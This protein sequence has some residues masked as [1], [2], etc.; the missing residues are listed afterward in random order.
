MKLLRTILI[1]LLTGSSV[2][3]SAV[4]EQSKTWDPPFDGRDPSVL[5][6]P[7]SVAIYWRHGWKRNP[8]D[9]NGVRVTG[10]FPDARYFS[11]N[12]YNDDTKMTLGSF[13]D[14]DLVPD[15]GGIN[16]FKGKSDSEGKSSYTIDIL[17]EGAKSD[18]KNV[19][20][21][22]DSVQNVSFLL[23]FYVSEKDQK[24]NRPLPVISTLNSETGEVTAGAPSAQA[25]KV[26]KVEIQKYL[27]PMFKEM[28]GKAEKNPEAVIEMIHKR[29]QGDSLSVKELV[30]KQVVA[31][32]FRYFQP[33]GILESYNFN[34]SGTY[35]NKDNHY[36]VIPVIRKNDDVLVVKFRAPQFPASAKDYPTS[37]VR[38]FSLSQGDDITYNH[39]TIIDR[40]F[41]IGEDGIARVMIG[42]DSDAL[43]KKAKQMVYNYMP[44]KVHEKMLLVYRH[45]IPRADFANGNDKVPTIDHSKPAEGQRGTKF[46]GDY[47]PTG[48]LIPLQDVLAAEKLDW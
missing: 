47:A 1:I 31:P 48:K 15:E 14:Y 42:D 28:A 11:F 30:C 32:A 10:E 38:Y 19:L 16:P 17:P 12:V 41:L 2:W 3:N 29:Q 23:R 20:N 35:P 13:S 33:G 46:I 4:A 36:L 9:P 27:L 26:S 6:L 8:G 44:W 37:P 43:R 18:L 7:D 34:T 21:F 39:G 25:P 24:G 22:P 5:Y 45:M 40:D